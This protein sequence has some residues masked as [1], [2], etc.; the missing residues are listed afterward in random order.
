MLDHMAQQ[1]GARQLTRVEV[2]PIGEPLARGDVVAVLERVANV[3]EV[4][5][6]LAKPERH[7]QHA[8]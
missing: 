2:A 3:G 4:M 6:E 5:A 1:F 8:D 7:I